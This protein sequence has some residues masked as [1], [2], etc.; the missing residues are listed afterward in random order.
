[1]G[2]FCCASQRKYPLKAMKLKAVALPHLLWH[3]ST[4][5]GLSAIDYYWML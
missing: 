1:M 3:A 2:M 4:N 5:V